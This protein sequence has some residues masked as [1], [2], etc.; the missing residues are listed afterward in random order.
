M[1]LQQRI[2]IY[3]NIFQIDK[4]EKTVENLPDKID[5]TEDG[6]WE[7]KYREAPMGMQQT[8]IIGIKPKEQYSSFR[9]GFSISLDG[10]ND[11]NNETTEEEKKY[12]I[13]NFWRYRR[14]R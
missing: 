2:W 5:V 1:K 10:N 13:Y 11:E 7:Y 12:S 6:E 4:I 3:V 9:G 14:Y 8:E